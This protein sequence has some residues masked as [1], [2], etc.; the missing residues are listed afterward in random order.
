MVGK[1]VVGGWTLEKGLT[2]YLKGL[3]NPGWRTMTGEISGWK[4][5]GWW[6]E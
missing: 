4:I 6:L 1:L 2:W 3:R 5:S